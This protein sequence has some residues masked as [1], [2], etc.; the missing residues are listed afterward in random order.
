LIFIARSPCPFGS[1]RSSASAH[2]QAAPVF[3]DFLAGLAA[4]V[5]DLVAFVS[6]DEDSFE[7]P[8][9]ED[10]EL[11]LESLEEEDDEAPGFGPAYRSEYQPPPLS[12]KL[13]WLMSFSTFL[14]LHLGQVRTG[15][16]DIFCHSSKRWPHAP[17]AYS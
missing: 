2:A 6:E 7:P 8:D 4:F 10:D 5:S 12:V 11:P 17:Q 1:L 9:S 13:V 14:A 15:L 16:S 3:L